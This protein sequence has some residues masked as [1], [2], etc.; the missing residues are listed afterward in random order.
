MYKLLLIAFTLFVTEAKAQTAFPSIYPGYIQ[1]G[2]FTNNLSTGDSISAKK[3]SFN[4][5]SGLSTSFTFFKG[6]SA[7]VFAAPIGLQ[8]NRRLTN[9]LYAFANVAIAP[10]Y[11]RFNQQFLNTNVNKFGQSNSYKSNGLNV[12]SSASLGLMYINDAKT[13]SISGSISVEKS[14][15]PS[16]PFYPA[17]ITRPASIAP[18]TYR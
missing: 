14:S 3:W 18:A 6:G 10:A 7:T 1:H 5:F 13:F 17:T 11:V 16:M 4:K 2:S 9:N 12:Y 15:Y 8:V